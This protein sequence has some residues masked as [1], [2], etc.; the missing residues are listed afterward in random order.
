MPTQPAS[1]ASG[2]SAAK[3]P[4]PKRPSSTA[5]RRKS[6]VSTLNAPVNSNNIQVRGGWGGYVLP[7]WEGMHEEGRGSV[8]L[9]LR[10]VIY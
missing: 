10:G 3:P 9:E 1:S 8:I 7:T 4:V 6:S 2:G 5:L